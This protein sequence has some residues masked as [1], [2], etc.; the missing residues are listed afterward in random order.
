MG[1]PVYGY[2]HVGQALVEEEGYRFWKWW[3][4]IFQRYGGILSCP[5]AL[6]V[7]KW[8]RAEQTSSLHGDRYMADVI[9]GLV[10]WKGVTI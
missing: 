3:S 8:E 2:T 7:S 5:I 6:F 10:G 4:K 9:G 1:F